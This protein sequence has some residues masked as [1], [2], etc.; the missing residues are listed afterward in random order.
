MRISE[1]LKAEKMRFI[2]LVELLNILS[3]HDGG[4]EFFES[5]RFLYLKL[6]T[7]PNGT[8]PSWETIPCPLS[9]RGIVKSRTKKWDEV[10]SLL[11][12]L[13]YQEGESSLSDEEFRKAHIY[14]FD[15]GEIT[16]FMASCGVNIEVNETILEQSE[17]ASAAAKNDA[18]KPLETKERNVL[19][20][21]IATLCK[22]AKLDYTKHAKIAGL[23]QSTAASMGLSIGETTIGGHL[24][25]IPNALAGRMK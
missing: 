10:C 5:A 14:G 19:L 25:K 20:T 16:A 23:I 2:S 13:S 22:E 15:R 17:R 3:A 4:C 9:G 11:E 21:I 8:R 7:A 18:E 12:C 1:L 24:K 6:S